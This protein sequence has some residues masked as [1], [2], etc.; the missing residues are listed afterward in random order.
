MIPQKEKPC[1]GTGQ[2]KGY[3]CGVMTKH[4]I[5]GLG[6]MCGCY[7]SWLLNTD[8]GKLKIEKATLKATK[9]RL[10]FEKAQKERS[11]QSELKRAL[12]ATKTAVHAYVRLRDKNKP[13]ISCGKQWNDNFQ[14]GHY[15][16]AQLYE[17]LRFNLLNINGQ[18]PECNIHNDGNLEQY[19]INL[20]LRIG[21]GKYDELLKLAQVDKH[22]SKVWNTQNLKEIRQEIKLLTKK[23][24]P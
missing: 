6:K 3:G 21:Q 18:C 17:T 10:D 5:Y 7:S 12:E 9:P 1:K 4:R 2:A 22:Y 23:L 15:H 11:T 20:P 24:T 14:A 8:A 19:S 13:C 16:K